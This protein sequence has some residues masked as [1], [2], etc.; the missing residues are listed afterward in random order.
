VGW[1][2]DG[3]EEDNAVLALWSLRGGK[4][5]KRGER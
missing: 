2:E 1:M 5:G 3:G 4:G